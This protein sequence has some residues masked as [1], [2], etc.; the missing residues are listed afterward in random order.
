VKNFAQMVEL[1]TGIENKD[2]VKNIIYGLGVAPVE[3]YVPEVI[4]ELAADVDY[5]E[6]LE[7]TPHT[8]GE[9]SVEKVEVKA[10][11]GPNDVD[12]HEFMDENADPVGGDET[13]APQ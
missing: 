5:E 10:E 4:L 7:M 13:E 11:A 3:L 2:V 12:Y 6:D 8:E 9:E 1:S